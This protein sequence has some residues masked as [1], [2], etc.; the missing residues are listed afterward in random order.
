MFDVVIVSFRCNDSLMRCLDALF[1]HEID[2]ISSVTVVE[3][4][5]IPLPDTLKERFPAISWVE[6]R[7][8]VGFA[9]G[10]NAGIVHGN[11]PFIA[12]LNPDTEIIAP[13]FHHA[14]RYFRGHDNVAVIGPRIIDEDGRLQGSARAFPSIL[15]TFFGRSSMLSRI[16]PNNPWTRANILNFDIAREEPFTPDWVSGA[17]ML[18]RRSAVKD[19]GLMDEKSFMYWEDCDW[20][21][22]FRERGWEI[23]YHPGLGPVMHVCGVS[24]SKVMF[25]TACYFHK[26]A[27]RL[28]WKYDTSPLKSMSLVVCAGASLRFALMC[29]V[30]SCRYVAKLLRS[31]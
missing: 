28:Y 24:S 3:N 22:R 25:R 7:E 17:C 31:F 2:N 12:L 4:G 11:A 13:F 6:N 27:V 23:V 9:A 29:V 26:S 18:V 8:N 16:F 15:T 30:M 20:C 19:T 21:R 10:C 1:T 5:G 14:A